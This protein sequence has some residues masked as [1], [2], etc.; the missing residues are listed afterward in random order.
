MTNERN[1]LALTTLEEQYRHLATKADIKILQED[2]DSVKADNRSVKA[3]IS[4][5]KAD[6]NS[7]KADV[8][9]IR[10]NMNRFGNRFDTIDATLT[11]IL[12]LLNRD[13]P[14]QQQ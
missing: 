8:N 5:M 3:D 7:M 12:N 4:L 2:L 9:S 10:S 11:L 14:I 1:G 6:I 13:E